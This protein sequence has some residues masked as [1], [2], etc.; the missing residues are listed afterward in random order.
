MVRRVG[1]L[2]LQAGWRAGEQDEMHPPLELEQARQRWQVTEVKWTA[3]SAE[4]MK[5]CAQVEARQGLG[6]GW[7]MDL[8]G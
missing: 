8:R 1:G 7:S 5:A 3:W 4:E 2:Q 6:P